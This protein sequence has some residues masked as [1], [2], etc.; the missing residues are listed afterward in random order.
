MLFAQVVRHS[1]MG[2]WIIW[3][4]IL[5]AIIAVALV[6][7]RAIG[8]QPPPWV[9]QIFGILLVAFVVILAI[10]FLLTL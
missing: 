7:L 3:I 2:E 1:P 6:G 9:W 5:A 4:V 10:R 8:F